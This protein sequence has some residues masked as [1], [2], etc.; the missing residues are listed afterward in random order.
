M[1]TI[2]NRGMYRGYELNPNKPAGF[3]LNPFNNIQHKGETLYKDLST[4]SFPNQSFSNNPIIG[5]N[6]FTN[7]FAGGRSILDNVYGRSAD[8]DYR[9]NTPNVVRMAN[10]NTTGLLRN[11]TPTK[12]SGAFVDP[13]IN[14]PLL[15]NFPELRD[16]I[17]RVYS[18]IP[19]DQRKFVTV[20]DGKVVFDLPEEYEMGTPNQTEKVP[21]NIPEFNTE[22]EYLKA[23]GLLD[24]Q[25]KQ[26]TSGLLN[27]EPETK[28]TKGLLDMAK[29]FVSS[30]YGR[31][32]ALGMLGASGYSK[33]PKS[34]GQIIQEADQYATNKALAKE[35]LDIKRGNANKKDSRFAYIVKDPNTGN[36]YNAY[37]TKDGIVVDVN[38]QN[39]PFR[40]DMFGGERKATISNVGNIN[41]QDITPNKMLALSQDITNKENQLVNLSR[42]MENVDNSYV[43]MEKLA[44]QFKTMM[45]TILNDYDLTPQELNQAILG[46]QFDGLIGQ[47][48]LEIVGGGVMTEPDA[49]KIMSALGGDPDKIDTNPMIAIEQMSNIFAQKYR[50]YAN[51]LELYN[52][53]ASA[54]GF[55]NYP[56]KETITFNDNFLGVIS[57]SKLL[58]LDLAKIPEFTE[59]QLFRLLSNNTDIDG[60]VIEERFT[61]DQIADIIALAKV[62]GI[63][64]KLEDGEIV[65]G[66]DETFPNRSSV[67]GENRGQ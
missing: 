34:L 54:G 38:G 9:I 11:R 48:R 23:S 15:R 20:Q 50:T 3:V 26:P 19:E 49:L 59:K 36:I 37:D 62:Y 45:K 5:E 2:D 43:G 35:E 63:D 46:G 32:F 12:S 18:Q 57:P 66:D 51:E 41:D 28:E 27:K 10:A 30:D 21:S 64:L 31:N 14:D 53:N 58:E 22:Q 67:I 42:Y 4:F 1:S 39:Q 61:S 6:K 56:K 24:Q 40:N 44:V 13:N 16:S 7:V 60:N 55:T 52:I 8:R 33:M 65:S 29:D 47:N 17:N 25:G